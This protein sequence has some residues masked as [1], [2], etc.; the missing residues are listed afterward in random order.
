M[1]NEVRVVVRYALGD[2]VFLWFTN[3]PWFSEHPCHGTQEDRAYRR[4]EKESPGDAAHA[5]LAGT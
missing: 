2:R 4:V 3:F 5:A 1:A